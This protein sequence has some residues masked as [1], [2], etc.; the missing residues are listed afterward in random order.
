[1]RPRSKRN[2][3]SKVQIRNYL[4]YFRVCHDKHICQAMLYTWSALNVYA[5]IDM[6]TSD[7][8]VVD[9]SVGSFLVVCSRTNDT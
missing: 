2:F 9:R 6:S 7:Y 1:M 4:N 8:V 5:R 3:A